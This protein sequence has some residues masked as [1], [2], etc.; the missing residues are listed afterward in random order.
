MGVKKVPHIIIAKL[1]ISVILFSF[2][3]L[4]ENSVVGGI[5]S[6]EQFKRQALI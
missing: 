3:S 5:C 1:G 4:E 6:F 2:A